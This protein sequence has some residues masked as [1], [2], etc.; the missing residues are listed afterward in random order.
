MQRV[1]R[2]LGDDGRSLKA[3]CR[4]LGAEGEPPPTAALAAQGYQIGRRKVSM[5]WHAT[6][7]ARMLKEPCYWG[8]AVAYSYE[9]F[10]S[11][12][13]DP[14]TNRL[15]K[16]KRT[17]YRDPASEMIVRYPPD[18]WPPIVSKE[19]AQRAVVRL[20]QNRMEADRNLKHTGQSF[21]R[22]GL[23][24]CGYCGANMHLHAHKVD[25]DAP[26]ILR[27]ICGQHR[28]YVARCPLAKPCAAVTQ[29]S[30]RVDQLEDAVWTFLFDA[31]R[32]PARVPAAY[33]R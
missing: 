7:I 19:L 9:A 12:K 23:A 2:E 1:Y 31:L 3:I 14:K 32:D 13:R 5:H 27:L 18:N 15:R 11:G 6:S 8:E 21:L 4:D 30:A 33:E 29:F 24:K 20:S 16:T 17:R 10:D 26:V 28:A 22:A 25:K